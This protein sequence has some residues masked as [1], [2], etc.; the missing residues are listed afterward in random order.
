MCGAGSVKGKRG[1][2]NVHKDAAAEGVLG[3]L[4][5][6]VD[7]HLFDVEHREH[8]RGEDEQD[9]LREL[10]AWACAV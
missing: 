1:K 4:D 9:G 3:L 7:D 5:D 6:A 2:G 8:G 10:C